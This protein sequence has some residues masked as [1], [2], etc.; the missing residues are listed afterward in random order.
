[1]GWAAVTNGE[2]LAPASRRFDVLV[3]L[4]R[5]LSFQQNTATLPLSIIVLRGR[6]SRLADLLPLLPEL[7]TA[8]DSTKA[9]GV[10]TIS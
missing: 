10:T 5:N 9:G 2:L 1:M 6:T 3:T 7:L 8:I 4:D